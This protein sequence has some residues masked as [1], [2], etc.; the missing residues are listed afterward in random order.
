MRLIHKSQG[1]RPFYLKAIAIPASTV[2]DPNDKNPERVSG[3]FTLDELKQI[4]WKGIGVKFNH[5]PKDVD[6]FV[7]K[8]IGGQIENDGSVSVAIEIPPELGTGPRADEMR[9]LKDKIIQSMYNG[10][11]KDVSVAHKTDFK[12]DSNNVG[13]LSKSIFEISLTDEGGREGS[14]IEFGQWGEEEEVNSE[15]NVYNVPDQYVK[16]SCCREID[17]LNTEFKSTEILASV[18]YFNT[19]ARCIYRSLKEMTSVTMTPEEIAQMKERLAKYEE[20]DNKRKRKESEEIVHNLKLY[21][22]DTINNVVNGREEKDLSAEEAVMKS[23]LEQDQKNICEISKNIL[24]GDPKTCSGEALM[25][26]MKTHL[27]ALNGVSFYNS[28][29]YKTRLD[30]E[31][32]KRKEA[33]EK[34][35]KL[36]TSNVASSTAPAATQEV[37]QKQTIESGSVAQ[38]SKE[39]TDKIASYKAFISKEFDGMLSQVKRHKKE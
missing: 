27:I 16:S 14:K 23:K 8:V 24:S 9:G 12:I 33:E 38:N 19:H 4:N 28:K 13:K 37:P 34:I 17:F 2:L 29:L 5:E 36:E 11:L 20:Q 25:E 22:D 21:Y 39:D 3:E 31:I 18:K 10:T 26:G 6:L 7:G 35:K 15:K 1:R 32:A 30:D